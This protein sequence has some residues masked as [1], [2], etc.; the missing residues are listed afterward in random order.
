MFSFLQAKASEKQQN[1]E[2][3]DNSNINQKISADGPSTSTSGTI[4]GENQE[5]SG[6]LSRGPRAMGGSA[7][8]L[9]PIDL[10]FG[11]YEHLSMGERRNVLANAIS[12]L[13]QSNK[14]IG[15]YISAVYLSAGTAEDSVVRELVRSHATNSIFKWFVKHDDHYHI[16]HDCTYS[17]GC[18]RCFNKYPFTRKLR[19]LI[20]V[21]ALTAEDF[22][23]LVR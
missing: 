18:C 3:S 4:G 7:D 19:R 9:G 17:S 14:R 11:G 16:V 13:V 21:Q 20:P 1:V 15:K 22:E 12:R 23:L 2:S 5:R 6:E 10:L 8:P